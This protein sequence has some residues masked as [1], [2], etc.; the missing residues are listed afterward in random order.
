M[1]R[2][3]LSRFILYRPWESVFTQLNPSLTMTP[4][5]PLP[6]VSFKVPDILKSGFATDFFFNVSAT[7]GFCLFTSTGGTLTG[8]LSAYLRIRKETPIATRTH[9]TKTMKT[10]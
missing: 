9:Q 10:V 1:K 2:A 5:T 4:A 6:S 8:S 7:C 3:K